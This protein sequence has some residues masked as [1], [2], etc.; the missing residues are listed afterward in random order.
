MAVIHG[1]IGTLTAALTAGV[2]SIIVSLFV[3]QPIWG[4][5]ISKKGVGLH[6]PWRKM[7][8]KSL[9]KAVIQLNNDAQIANNAVLL[10]KKLSAEDGA[11]VAVRYIRHYFE[12]VVY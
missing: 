1:G 6:L 10:S 8:P 2:P 4:Q 7:T 11:G 9:V 3:D 5:L 12:S